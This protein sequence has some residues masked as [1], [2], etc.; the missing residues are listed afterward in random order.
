MGTKP[1]K[2]N[3]TSAEQSYL[4]TC[5]PTCSVRDLSLP[6]SRY[7]GGRTDGTARPR[8][9]FRIRAALKF[10]LGRRIVHGSGLLGGEDDV[11]REDLVL[12]FDLV[13][14]AIGHEGVV[15]TVRLGACERIAVLVVLKTPGD[16]IVVAARVRRAL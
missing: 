16:C 12:M 9:A 2:G 6:P 11:P 3:T 8:V 14:V 10:D 5:L 4:P 1:P 13:R 7:E 15:A